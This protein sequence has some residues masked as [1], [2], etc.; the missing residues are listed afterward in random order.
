MKLDLRKDRKSL[1]KYIKDR[2]RDYPVYENLGPGED[3]DPIAQITLGYQFDQAGWAALVFDTRADAAVDGVWQNYIE[4]NDHE[5]PH[6]YQAHERNCTLRVA[7][8]ITSVFR[9]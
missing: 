9:Q 3:E 7:G 8:R 2:I 4:E 5:L 6:W 1:L